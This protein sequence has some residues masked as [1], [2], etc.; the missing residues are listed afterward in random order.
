MRHI[1][2]VIGAFLVSAVA[3]GIAA[4][5]MVLPFEPLHAWLV[6]KIAAEIAV[7]VALI[8][9]IPAHLILIT[10][11]KR[12]LRSYLTA[13]VALSGAVTGLFAWLGF[14]ELP[15]VVR[16][17]GLALLF[18]LVGTLTFWFIARPGRA[19]GNS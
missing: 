5:M 8:L 17:G 4:G 10:V 14:S 2:R 19:R 3:V 12:G 11:G 16:I 18:G 7:S 13:G 15:S 1:A 6:G 9:G